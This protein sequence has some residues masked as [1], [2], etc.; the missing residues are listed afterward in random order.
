MFHQLVLF[1]KLSY[2]K[3]K[4]GSE[5]NIDKDKL[6]KK[7]PFSSKIKRKIDSEY[8]NYIIIVSCIETFY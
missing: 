3:K 5:T 1:P 7:Y 6:N 8:L 4:K 2:W